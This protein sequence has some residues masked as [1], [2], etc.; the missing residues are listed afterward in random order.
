MAVAVFRESVRDRV[1]YN[2][3][4]FAVLLVGASILIGQLTAGQDVKIIKD[5]GLDRDVGVRSVRRDLRRYQPR[6][7]GGRSTEHLS[8]PGQTCPP[9]GFIVGK[10]CGLLLTLLV[11]VIVMTLALYAG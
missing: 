8:A 9:V 2:L 3:V 5:L 1:F 11:N 6:V 10:F 4:L 7:E